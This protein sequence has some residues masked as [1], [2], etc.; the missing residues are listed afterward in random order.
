MGHGLG[1]D[2]DAGDMTRAN[3]PA[4]VSGWPSRFADR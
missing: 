1:V 2:H 3:L 4:H